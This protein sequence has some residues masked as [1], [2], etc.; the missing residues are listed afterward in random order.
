MSTFYAVQQKL[1]LHLMSTSLM[2]HTTCGH[3]GKP[4]VGVEVI[5]IAQKLS[6]SVQLVI[7]LGCFVC[8]RAVEMEAPLPA[9]SVSPMFV[10]TLELFK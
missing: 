3:P 7:G 6:N 10:T 4:P 1:K 9:E 5:N 2:S 8:H